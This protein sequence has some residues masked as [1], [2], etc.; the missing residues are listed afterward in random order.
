MPSAM[1]LW[2]I[3]PRRVSALS[4]QR[5]ASV[6]VLIRHDELNQLAQTIL[7]FQ[8]FA[9]QPALTEYSEGILRRYEVSP[10]T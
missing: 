7:M 3:E 5:V 8:P 2:Y 9:A 1:R 6:S 4:Y 10:S